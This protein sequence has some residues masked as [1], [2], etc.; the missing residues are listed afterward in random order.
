MHRFIVVALIGA[1]CLCTS[2]VSARPIDCAVDAAQALTGRGFYFSADTE[3]WQ[4]F[5]PSNSFVCGV[6]IEL[7]VDQLGGA[8]LLRIEDD[9]GTVLGQSHIDASELVLGDGRYAFDLAAAVATGELHRLVLSTNQPDVFPAACFWL[10]DETSTYEDGASDVH[11]GGIPGFD[12]AF[13]V[14]TGTA[15]ASPPRPEPRTFVLHDAAP[16][17]F[18]P[19]TTLAF[20]L[21]AARHLRLSIHDVTGRLVVTLVDGVREPGHHTQIWDGRDQQRRRVASGVYLV[22]IEVD[23]ETETRRAVLLK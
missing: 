14:L 22:R 11:F 16:N 5:V 9:L 15:T 8:L 13:S 20:E 1:T 17:P 23:D 18:N 21:T 6:E 19:A 3:R 2:A 7:R 4:E 10:G 12:Y